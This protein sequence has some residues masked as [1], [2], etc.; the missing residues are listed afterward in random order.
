MF[1]TLTVTDNRWGRRPAPS[2]LHRIRA[3]LRSALNAAIRDG[4]IRDNP[5]RFVQLPTPRRP[6]ALVWTA[7]RTREWRRTGQ[8]HSVAVWTAA[9]V[10]EF[11][12]LAADDRLYAM[13]WL[14]ALRG[15][16]RGEG[17]GLRW[18]D[19]DLDE[20]V[21]TISQQRITYGRITTDG[22]PKTAASRRTIALDKA[23][24]QILRE[25]RR[26]QLREA[27]DSGEASV[28]SGY[29]FTS[30]NGGPLNPDYLT[31]RFAS[32]VKASGLPPIR[33]YDLRHGA[34]TLAHAAGADLKTVQ[35][36]LGHTSIVL[37]A[38]TY[39]SVLMQ[40]HFKI[41]EATAQLVLSAAAVNP[42]QRHRPSSRAAPDRSAARNQPTHP[43]PVRPKRNRRRSKARR[44]HTRMTHK[45]Q[46]RIGMKL[47][48]LL[49]MGAP[50][51]TRTPNP[52]IK[53][54]TEDVPDGDE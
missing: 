30:P 39:T 4:L 11:L 17:A 22:P 10:A 13:W 48:G 43:R 41:A 1:A 9:R 42:G 53:S 46:D 34:A 35:E 26:R 47:Y 38:D 3:T 12:R 29:V 7:H 49:D 50:P 2:T 25:H 5:A 28:Q 14:I 33:L 23:T 31:R 27:R 8:R 51:G 40:L 37:T 15:L 20:R 36:F 52:R 16:R 24:V 6:Q 44:R 54:G 21:V 19:V 32:L 45:D 18:V